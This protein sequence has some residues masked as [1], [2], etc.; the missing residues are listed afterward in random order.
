MLSP[1]DQRNL[2][3]PLSKSRCN[4]PADSAG[5]V[6]ANFHSSAPLHALQR[7]NQGITHGRLESPYVRAVPIVVE[8]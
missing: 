6:N 4:M 8:A 2:G 7:A 5:S 1:S 3:S